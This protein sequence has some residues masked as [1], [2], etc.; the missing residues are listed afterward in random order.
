MPVARTLTPVGG[1]DGASIQAAI[2]EVSAL[3]RSADGFRGAVLLKAGTYEVAGSVTIRAS[4]VV[5]R[6]EGDGPGG[7][8]IK[9]VGATPRSVIRI[10]GV[11]DRAKVAGSKQPIT[12]G[13]V[14]VGARTF[15][16]A[17]ASSLHAGDAV[18]VVR[19]PNQEWIDAVGMD[20]CTGIGTSYDTADVDGSTCI[21]ESFWKPGDRI[22]GDTHRVASPPHAR[23]WSIGGQ[24]LNQQGDG[25]FES[26][27]APV[28]PSSLYLQ[29]LRDR[30][31]DGALPNI[32][33]TSLPPLPAPPAPTATPTPAPSPSATLPTIVFEAETTP[34]ATSPGVSVGPSPDPLASNKIWVGTR[35]TR[36]AASMTSPWTARRRRVSYP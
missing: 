16:V 27:G 31:G 18:L 25:E 8:L 22:V 7:T 17:D 3:P 5:L 2:D 28:R 30:L 9:V 34:V 15:S 13:Y 14:P 6:G 19:M 33:Y 24:A 12:D 36:T 20:A 4:G 26:Y 35:P 29:Q 10:A 11:G 1:D 23:N 21:S 32:G